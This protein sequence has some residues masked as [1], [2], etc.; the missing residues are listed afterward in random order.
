MEIKNLV[1]LILFS[2]GGATLIL[3]RI[4][5]VFQNHEEN[6]RVKK[7][8]ELGTALV[9]LV[10][11]ISM[12]YYIAN[13]TKMQSDVAMMQN[14]PILAS[15]VIYVKRFIGQEEQL[16]EVPILTFSNIG[17]IIKNLEISTI[18]VLRVDTINKSYKKEKTYFIP[19]VNVNFSTNIHNTTPNGK[20]AEINLVPILTHYGDYDDGSDGGGGD[21]GGGGGGGDGGDGGGGGGGGDDWTLSMVSFKKRQ[22]NEIS[23]RELKDILLTVGIYDEPEYD[24]PIIYGDYTD[25]VLVSCSYEDTFNREHFELYFVTMYI[26]HL[27]MDFLND[28]NETFT[29]YHKVERLQK[30]DATNIIEK[31]DKIRK[32]RLYFN[33]INS[34]EDR[35]NHKDMNTKRL[36]ELLK[37]KDLAINTPKSKTKKFKNNLDSI[38]FKLD[39][40]EFHRTKFR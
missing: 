30:E 19:V 6:C 7:N 29:M 3:Y 32:E 24:E 16:D 38:E 33:H 15:E 13:Y 39:R 23:N 12:N 17:G 31:L 26:P 34:K 28:E 10:F 14:S 5:K 2:V 36:K 11:F 25:G 9:T 8:L 40:D 27:I 4:N 1:V 35:S 18:Q 20:V 37:N 22:L 21:D